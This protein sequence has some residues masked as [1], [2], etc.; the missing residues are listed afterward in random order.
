M[1]HPRGVYFVLSEKIFSLK[2]VNVLFVA[3]KINLGSD[4]FCKFNGHLLLIANVCPFC[5]DRNIDFH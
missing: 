2:V 3:I 4:I 1:I 5:S